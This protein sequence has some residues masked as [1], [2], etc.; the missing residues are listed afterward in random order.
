VISAGSLSLTAG[1]KLAVA[2]TGKHSYLYGMT[3]KRRQTDEDEAQSRRFIDL[4]H[5]L[6]T[7]GELDPEEDGQ[8][9]ER[10][11]RKVTPDRRPKP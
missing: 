1:R 4:A 8:A 5:E 2:E 3:Q 6:E 9:F 10:L 11:V 7:K